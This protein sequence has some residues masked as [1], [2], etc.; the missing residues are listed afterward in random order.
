MAS[1]NNTSFISSY[2]LSS[3]NNWLT[4][5]SWVVKKNIAT[6][7]EQHGSEHEGK[8]ILDAAQVNE[9]MAGPYRIF[10]KQLTSC[11]SLIVSARHQKSLN[12]EDMFQDYNSKSSDELTDSEIKKLE[13]LELK[14]IQ[15]QLTD[16]FLKCDAQWTKVVDTWGDAIIEQL[17]DMKATEQE[18]SIF[19]EYDPMFEL[20]NRFAELNIKVPK[21]KR[22]LVSFADYMKLKSY[23][24]VYSALSRQHL[25]HTDADVLAVLKPLKSIFDQI[26]QQDG[27]LHEKQKADM[28]QVVLPLAFLKKVIAGDATK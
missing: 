23:L 22:G 3:L 7:K 28:E 13:S 11:Y 19:K 4:V 15:S 9:I 18:L 12:G 26:K 21:H 27:D 1:K 10:F 2:Y 17:H 16:E 14:K 6:L 20:Y 25:P 24:M 5:R 8:S